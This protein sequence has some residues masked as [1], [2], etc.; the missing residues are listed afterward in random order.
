MIG[1]GTDFINSINPEG[2]KNIGDVVRGL[3]QSAHNNGAGVNRLLTTASAVLDSPDQA[4][5][6]IASIISNVG[7]LTSVLRELRGPLKEIRARC[8]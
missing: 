8:G 6:D 1:S 2:S 4:I 5:S 3:D 7:Q